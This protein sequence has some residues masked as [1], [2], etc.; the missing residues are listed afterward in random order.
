[1]SR[2][3][4]ILGG[5]VAGMSAAHELAERG[6]H[7]EVFER[8]DV[9]GGK[10]RSIPVTEPASPVRPAAMGRAR[11]PWLPGEHGFRFFPG[12]YKHVVDT[13]KRIPF[14]DRTVAD[15]LVDTT[16]IQ[17][18]RNERGSVIVP[19]RF[20]LTPGE[21]KTAL[22]YVLGLLGGQLDVNVAET[23][24]LASKVWQVFTSCE[25]RRITEYERISW[26]DFIEAEGRSQGYQLLF[27][28]GITR[29]LVAAKARRASTKT[30]GDIFM[31]MLLYIVQPG[32]TAD[33]LLNG[34]TSHVWIQ[35]WLAQLRALGVVYH[36]EAEVAA[37]NVQGGRITSATIVER[38]RTFEA[39]A[40]YYLAALPVER[41][42]EF[43]TPALAAADPSL[44]NIPPLSENVEWM[45][46]IQFY[47]TVDVPLTHGH[48]IFLE[49]PWALTSVSQA[50]FWPD[51]DLASHGD[52]KVR[53][54][55]S[56]DISSW[57]TPGLNGKTAMQC[58]RE[59]IKQEVWNQIQLSVNVGGKEILKDEH[60]H[61][62]FLDPDIEDT[63][64]STPGNETNIEPL[65]VNYVDTWKL[66]PEAA[67]RIPNFFLASDYVRTHTD[68]ATMEGANEA[69]RRATNGII[70]ASG[71]KAKPC[72]IWKLHEPE[73]LTPLRAF[74]RQRF[75]RGLAWDGGIVQL[76]QHALGLA[77]AAS[78]VGTTA[79]TD[80]MSAERAA[81]L[82]RSI[83]RSAQDLAAFSS[84]PELVTPD[85]SPPPASSPSSAPS[86][87]PRIRILSQ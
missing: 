82:V 53:G 63:D 59:E 52:G 28:H 37:I 2:K 38:N 9:P 25:E 1:M 67:T 79:G 45:N 11:K 77:A 74:D 20:P 42:A 78:T 44:A 65:L 72:E 40:D 12:F 32:V 33:R 19:A 46:G 6:F 41:M 58:S 75:R 26:W 13:M 70:A 57:T 48:T 61:F 68:L 86:S 54:I 4:I 18:A 62:W 36:M 16:Q 35:P 80:S 24:F 71:S 85:T 5:G 49:S 43:V 34:P 30:I 15:N 27:G 81:E 23:A 39:R 22:Y 7:V 47:L 14:R 10:A 56:V 60:L 83:H 87:A 55:L 51:F 66:R 69:A 84:A 64:P 8:R 73:L 50:Q 31:Q 3:V 17:I 76:A 29:S 21:L